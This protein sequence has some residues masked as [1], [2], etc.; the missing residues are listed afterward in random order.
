MPCA[1][2]YH[3]TWT[4]YGQ[5]LRGDARGYV[6]RD[7]HT[8]GEPYPEG[9]LRVYNADAN[10]MSEEACWLSDA[11]R[12]L[13]EEAIGEACD[14]RGWRLWAVN[15]QPDHAHVVVGT[16][17][18]SGVRARQVLKDRS[19]RALQAT[20]GRRR[21][22]WTEGGKVEV[23]RS[24]GQLRVAIE[25]VNEKQP[26]AKVKKGKFPAA[27][28][29]GSNEQW[30]RARIRNNNLRKE[31]CDETRCVHGAVRRAAVR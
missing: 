15:V 8:P 20:D 19:T 3:L 5:W 26:F 17:E 10:R 7:H 1:E 12:V 31:T 14:F 18:V 16:P 11:Q 22:W 25:Y 28:A 9:D 6:D 21:H 4:C 2:T 27:S 24:D 30:R 13:A 29:A 23:I